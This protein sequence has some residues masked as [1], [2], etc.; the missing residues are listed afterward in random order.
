M[1]RGDL[2]CI[3]PVFTPRQKEGKRLSNRSVRLGRLI[4]QSAS[5][6]AETS[7]ALKEMTLQQ[8]PH[9]LDVDPKALDSGFCCEAGLVTWWK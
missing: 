1:Q 4:T 7:A 5:R 8:L 6:L 2:P 3:Y 9:A